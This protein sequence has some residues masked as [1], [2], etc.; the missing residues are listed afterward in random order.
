MLNVVHH[1]LQHDVINGVIL[2]FKSQIVL[3]FKTT[4]PNEL[5][6]EHDFL[7]PGCQYSMKPHRI[8]PRP[9]IFVVKDLQ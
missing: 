2:A 1:L 5:T 7:R 4:V 6:H 8:T 9:V 3:N